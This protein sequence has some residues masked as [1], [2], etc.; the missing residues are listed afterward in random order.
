MT[1]LATQLDTLRRWVATPGTFATAFPDATDADLIGLLAD[2]FAEAQLDGQFKGYSVDTA[3]EVTTPDGADMAPGD[4]ALVSLY[5]AIRLVRAQLLNRVTHR[6]YVGAGGVTFEEDYS[7][8][9]LRDVLAGLL[10]QKERV[11]EAIAGGE[12][13]SAGFYM[14]DQYAIRAWA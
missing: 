5:A 1:A 7:V 9:M 12:L 13:G 10:A 11:L 8:N 4:L 6:R 14:A 3:G 2:G